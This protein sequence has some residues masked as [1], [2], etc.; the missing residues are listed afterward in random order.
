M[1]LAHQ[2]AVAIDAIREDSSLL[3]NHA[4]P[5]TFILGQAGVLTVTEAEVDL[6][7]EWPIVETAIESAIADLMGMREAEGRALQEDL[8]QHLRAFRSCLAEVEAVV[9][10]IN[11]RLRHRLDARLRR[12]ISDKVD[13]N[14]LT[15]EAAIWRINPM[16]PKS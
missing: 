10:G 8:E 15:M 6:T 4:V 1:D 3:G 9:V 14:R 12:L 13:Q 7:R 5:W 2:Y 11:E 16:W